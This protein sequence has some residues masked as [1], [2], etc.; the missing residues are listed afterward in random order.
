M[1]NSD[2]TYTVIIQAE[3]GKLHDP[4]EITRDEAASVTEAAHLA[5]E[6]VSAG[7]EDVEKVHA[8]GELF[9]A[10]NGFEHPRGE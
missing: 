2:W 3:D 6:K 9:W 1:T 8:F 10:I 4:V 5:A 7:I